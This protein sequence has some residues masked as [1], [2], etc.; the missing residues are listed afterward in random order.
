MMSW[1]AMARRTLFS[2]GV[3]KD[4]SFIAQYL[5]PKLMRDLHLF[6]IEDDD[7]KPKLRVVAIHGETRYRK[8][9]RRLSE[10][11][12]LG[13]REPKLQKVGAGGTATGGRWGGRRDDNRG[14]LLLAAGMAWAGSPSRAGLW[15]PSIRQ[16]RDELPREGGLTYAWLGLFPIPDMPTKRS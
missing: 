6:S 15:K 12:N 7:R 4:E 10:Q 9:R 2:V 16:R 3:V 1:I 14:P 8:V 5:S 13:S 11:Y